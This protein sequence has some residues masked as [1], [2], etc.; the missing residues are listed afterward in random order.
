MVTLQWTGPRSLTLRQAR[1]SGCCRHNHYADR[2]SD[3]FQPSDHTV[4]DR[5]ESSWPNARSPST[6]AGPGTL[7]DQAGIE[8]LEDQI[9]TGYP[10]LLAIGDPAILRAE[11]AITRRHHNSVRLHAGIGYV[12]PH[13][14]HH[15]RCETPASVA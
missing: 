1:R 9:K 10:H 14:E 15:D 12:T 11:P 13:D 3:R 8:S 2:H 7:T 6:S 4:R 5:P